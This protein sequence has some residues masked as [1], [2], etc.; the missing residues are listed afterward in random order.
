MV[1]GCIVQA[2]MGSIRLPG[3]VLM[4]VDKKTPLI[5][6]LLTQL[7]NCKFIDKIVVATTNLNDD[8]EIEKFVKSMNMDCF[9]GSSLDVLDRYFKCAQHFSF[10]TIVRITADNPL[11]D[12]VLVDDVIKIFNSNSFDYISNAHIRSFPYGTETEVFSFN[13]LHKAW[14][15]AKTKYEREHVTPYFYNNQDKFSLHD[16][17]NNQNLSNFRWTVDNTDDL[18]LVKE[19]LSKIKQRPILMNDIIELFSKNPD[20]IK[21]NTNIS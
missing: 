10:S 9:R 6:N 19:I 21:I 2:R 18:K 15:N 11:I 3:K 16:V 8:D 5:Q 4:N 1:V 12:P 17:I 14:K 20:L 13:A 7:Q